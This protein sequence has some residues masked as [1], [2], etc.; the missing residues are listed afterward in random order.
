[1]LTC[2]IPGIVFPGINFDLVRGCEENDVEV[3]NIR[4]ILARGIQMPTIPNGAN[5][6]M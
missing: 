6:L 5:K 1:M 3:D 2:G 4:V